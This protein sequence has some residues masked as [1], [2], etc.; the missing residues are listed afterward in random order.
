MTR[1]IPHAAYRDAVLAELAVRAPAFAGFGAPVSVYFG[2]GTPG[3]W[4]ADCV[5]AVIDG[6]AARLGLA[7][8]A[9]ITVECNPED[10]TLDHLRGLRA[11]GVNRLSVGAQSFDDALLTRLGRAHDAGATRAAVDA[12][13]RAGFAELSLDL[14]HGAAGQPLAAALADVEAAC[15]LAPTHVSTY[16]LTIEDRTAFGARARRGESLLAPD[17]VLAAAFEQIRAAL[18]ARGVVPYEV[19]NAAVPGHEAVHNSLYWTFDPY[20]ALGAG[21]HGFWHDGA[22]GERWVNARA[23]RHYLA[24]ARSGAP[25]EASRERIDAATLLDERVL[26]GLRLDRGLPVDAALEARFG[27]A[28]RA[29]VRRGDLR[30]TDDGRWAVTDAARP[31]LN[32]V[33]LALL[34]APASR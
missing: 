22:V 17:D 19:S 18:R 8:G 11:A 7:A 25:A 10:V 16:Q 20:L 34:E 32:R 30:W 6:V 5:G 4:P 28:A 2:G 23:P 13:R 3:L 29:L 15:D 26:C 27:V 21:A 1:S 9:E 14:M 33:V 12:A 24:G 31:F